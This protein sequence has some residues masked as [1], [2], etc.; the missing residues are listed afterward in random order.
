[1]TQN[2]A[3]ENNDQETMRARIMNNATRLFVTSG[4]SAISMR[5][6]AAAV[7]VSKAGLY[8][9]FKDKENLFIAIL[10]ENLAEIGKIVANSRQSA[11][12]A[13]T[14]LLNLTTLIFRQPPQQRSV[15]RL[16]SQE[17]GNINPQSRSTFNAL[18]HDEFIGQIENILQEGIDRGEL[19]PNSPAI[20]CWILLGMMYPFFYPESSRNAVSAEDISQQIVD[21]FFNGLKNPGKKI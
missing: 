12:D 15:I 19:R 10:R 4:Y 8:Y 9:H 2:P 7:G 17:M 13:Y 14:R 5:E 1:M 18:Y 6:I 3:L 11:P 16:A 20:T 21:L